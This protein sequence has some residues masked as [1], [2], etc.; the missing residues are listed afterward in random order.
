M[1]PPAAV[2][3]EFKSKASTS[4]VASGPLA[5]SRRSKAEPHHDPATIAAPPP[6][7]SAMSFMSPER[8]AVPPPMAAAP[9]MSPERLAML[10]SSGMPG[11]PA[12]Q[13][14]QSHAAQTPSHVPHAQMQQHACTPQP[15]VL[16][17]NRKHGMAEVGATT[18][19]SV[20]GPVGLVD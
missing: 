11:V 2:P 17:A 8:L 9:F 3:I 7:G 19:F 1:P 6:G 16:D 18:I 5:T 10:A 12:P 14:V 4:A 13:V 15:L 20:A